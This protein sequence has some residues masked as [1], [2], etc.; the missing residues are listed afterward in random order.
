MF[1][2]SFCSWVSMRHP[3]AS[4]C[5]LQVWD[6]NGWL[7]AHRP[8]PV[9]GIGMIDFGGSAVVHMSAGLCGFLGTLIIGPRIGRFDSNGKPV[10][11]A[12]HS[13]SLVVLGTCVITDE[14][15]EALGGILVEA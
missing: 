15:G 2:F 4:A 5:S 9:L 6:V 13:A 1:S 8:D 3:L 11:I 12:G 10:A 7:S 14:R